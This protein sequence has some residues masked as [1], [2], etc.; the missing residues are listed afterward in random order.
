VVKTQDTEV[1]GCPSRHVHA[2]RK[3]ILAGKLHN[4]GFLDPEINGNQVTDTGKRFKVPGH[5]ARRA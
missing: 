4:P 1:G 5:P 2:G 3:Y